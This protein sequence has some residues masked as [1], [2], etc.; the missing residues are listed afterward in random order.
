MGS[1]PLRAQY[2]CLCNITR[3]KSITIAKVLSSYPPNLSWRRDLVGVKMVAWNNLLPRIANLTLP[4]EPDS[5]H[6]NLSQNRV[7]SMKFHYQ[8]LI[9]VEVPNLNKIIWKIRVPQI[10]KIFLWYLRKG[11]LLTKDNLSKRN[12]QGNKSCVFCHNNETI[13]HL[14]FECRFTRILW[15]FF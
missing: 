14:L 11:V 1:T 3:P 13:E 6:W 12:W 15:A 4:Q 10:V 9:R 5:F 7:F 8:A 2:P